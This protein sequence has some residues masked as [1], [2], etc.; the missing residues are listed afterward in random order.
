MDRGHWGKASQVSHD[1]WREGGIRVVDDQGQDVPAQLVFPPAHAGFD[2]VN[3]LFL[4]DV[5]S[6]G[7]RVY[8]FL[9]PQDKPVNHQLQAGENWLE[10]RRWRLELD[11]QTGCVTRLYDKARD[12]EVLC[13]VAN[14]AVVIDDPSDTWAHETDGFQKEVGAFGEAKISVLETG[15]VRAS[16]WVR[17]RFGESKLEQ[18]ISLYDELDTIEF[19]TTV[20]WGE[21]MRMLKIEW[22]LNVAVPTVTSEI[23]YGHIVRLSKGNEE[24]TG[25][26]IDVSGQARRELI[27]SLP[28][29]VTMLNDSKYAYDVWARYRPYGWGLGKANLRLTALRSPIF[30]FHEPN[31]VQPDLPYPYQD[32]GPHTFR[33]ALLPHDQTWREA[34]APR[35]AEDFN[36][37]LVAINAETHGGE[38][39]PRLSFLEVSPENVQ[40]TVM[41]RGE[42]GD[43][44]VIR[45]VETH[46][47]DV[48]ATLRLPLLKIKHEFALGH[49]EIKSF[50]VRRDGQIVEVNLL[51]DEAH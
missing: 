51:E 29:G 28:Y 33:Y 27:H 24:P 19:A 8:H 34:N 22:P 31:Q 23:P 15:P 13:D 12:L 35:E 18:I 30:V 40:V 16:L 41:K 14:R 9:P 36:A 5:P 45:C 38:L 7:Y 26:W 37:P 1:W 32:Q 42:K 21:Q 47:Q 10:N 17:T 46:G 50:A 48:R 6:S 3:V 39:P 11:S 44:L 25:R 43:H 2:R 4:A 49:D 20:H